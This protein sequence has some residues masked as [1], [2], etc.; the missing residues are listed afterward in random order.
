MTERLQDINKDVDALDVELRKRGL[1]EYWRKSFKLISRLQDH[2]KAKDAEIEHLRAALEEIA[3]GHGVYG[4]QA[5]EYKQV[6]RRAL[7]K[8]AETDLNPT[9]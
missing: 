2:S 5:H 7:M 3:A 4:A 1:T 6:A 8:F 9:E